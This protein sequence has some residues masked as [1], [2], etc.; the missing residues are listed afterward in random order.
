LRRV[1]LISA[2]VC[3][4]CSRAVTFEETTPITV[5]G[6]ATPVAPVVE[7][8]AIVVREKIEFA[9]DGTVS[10]DSYELLEQVAATSTRNPE[11]KIIVIASVALSAA[12]EDALVAYLSQR[13]VAKDI[14]IM[15]E[16]DARQILAPTSSEELAP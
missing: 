9:P 8:D 10:P 13:G 3:L 2:V 5:I 1:A 15:N 16:P 6:P 14:E 12:Q 4:S 11:V 7:H